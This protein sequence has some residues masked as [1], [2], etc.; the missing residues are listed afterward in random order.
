MR[1]PS[2]A[3]YT[4][5]VQHDLRRKVA[6]AYRAAMAEGLSHHASWLRAWAIYAAETGEPAN[7]FVSDKTLEMNRL[8]ASAI[9]VDPKWFWRPVRERLDRGEIR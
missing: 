7:H 3:A 4:P 2:A 1:N 6:L 8:I 5:A 9:L